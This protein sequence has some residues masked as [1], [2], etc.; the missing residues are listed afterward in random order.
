VIVSDIIA[1]AQRASGILGVGQTALAQDTADAQNI[2]MLMLMQW[3]QKRW[4]V[5][6]LDFVNWPI[7]MGVGIYTVG[8]STTPGISPPP[9]APDVTVNGNY[10]PAN[11]QS[12]YLRLEA[13]LGQPSSSYPLDF[14]VQILRSRQEYDEIRLKAL[15]SWPGCIYYDPTI[16]YGTLYIWPI[17][18]QPN[19]SFYVA[20]QQAID[21]SAEGSMSIDF[22][23]VLPTET[24]M[25]IMY[26]LALEL[27]VNYKLP[28]DQQL[29]A[30]A[31]ASI[32]TL[33]MANFA[34]RPLQMPA[35]LWGG[36]GRLKNP[37]GGFYPEVA[38]GVPYGVLS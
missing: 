27:A 16:P 12:A 24:Q 34:L 5:F 1:L 4:L 7:T 23:S 26:G 13:G 22:D 20:F 25:A 9:A 8:P 19:F 21:L 18:I 33:R 17:P 31:R 3:R 32:N 14:P 6:R 2:L 11:I 15:Q 35:V 37:M 36:T 30:A 28:P 38:A 29:Q 10:R